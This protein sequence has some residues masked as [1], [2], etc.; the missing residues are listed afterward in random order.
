MNDVIIASNNKH[1]IKEIKDILG[2]C[3]DKVFSIK[4]FGIDIEIEE[5]GK[6]FYE[7]ALIKAKA[8]RKFTDKIILADDSGL[9]VDSLNGEP[10]VYSARFAGENCDYKENNKLLLERMKGEKN[11]TAK[12]V[13]CM[14]LF[15]PNGKII[16]GIGETEGIILEEEIG[17]NGF[18]YDPIFYSNDLKKS[19]GIAS[20]EEKNKISHRGRAL[21]SIKTSLDCQRY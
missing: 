13:C 4:E 2:D 6:T 14:V 1:K 8:I 18:G 16:S 3:F 19:F 20:E 17:K 15:F 7:N 9:V 11:R 21:E 12:F 10:G 5:T